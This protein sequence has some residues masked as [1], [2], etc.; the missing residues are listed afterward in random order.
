RTTRRCGA[1]AS[2]GRGHRGSDPAT[3]SPNAAAPRSAAMAG[4]MP[5]AASRRSRWR[6]P[7]SELTA[8]DGRSSPD[9]TPR[10]PRA[11]PTPSG[12]RGRAARPRTPASS[13]P[14]TGLSGSCDGGA[15]YA[16]TASANHRPRRWRQV[17]HPTPA[18]YPCRTPPICAPTPGVCG[19]C[20][21]PWGALTVERAHQHAEVE[22]GDMDQ[23]ALVD[24]LASAQPGAAHAAAIE[25]M[26]EAALDQ[27]AAPAHR[28]A[29]DPR[30]QPRPIGVDCFPGHLV[31]M[32]AKIAVGRLGFGDARLPYA[33]VERLQLAA[34]MI[35]LVG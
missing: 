10:S 25:D 18:T 27:F 12:C 8:P 20:G 33:A 22:A 28:L 32:P 30:F 19:L 3:S 9:A 1:T 14:G 34:R 11:S 17:H 31:A 21:L 15:R 23:V 2:Y 24:I 5:A 35:S 4:Q 16:C 7:N 6:G 29:P 13:P 26:G